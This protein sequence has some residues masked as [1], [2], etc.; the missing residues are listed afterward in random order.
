MKRLIALLVIGVLLTF[1]YG[2]AT[3]P[4]PLIT[5]NHY[6]NYQYGFSLYM[7]GG[8]WKISETPPDWFRQIFQDQPPQL[9]LFN[10]TING[11]LSVVCDKSIVEIFPN[12]NDSAFKRGFRLSLRETYRNKMAERIKSF[13][14]DRKKDPQ[15]VSFESEDL[16]PWAN[17]EMSWL[18]K[19]E[20][21]GEIIKI[22]RI[23]KLYVYP[24]KD[25]TVTVC[26]DLVYRLQDRE[27]GKRTW[28][29]LID[30]FKYGN[31]VAE[32]QAR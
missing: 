7:P 22:E 6:L 18:I 12:I 1:L 9:L 4:K 28:E 27:E 29:R 15:V 10:N 2:C 8:D 32:A 14:T 19:S 5:N 11:V 16:N 24:L 17:N 26:I 30:S 31:H 25:E 13:E 3:T 23:A 21:H 20:T